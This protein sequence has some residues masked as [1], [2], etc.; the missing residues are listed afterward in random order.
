MARE[1]YASIDEEK[2]V[3]AAKLAEI[4]AE[5]EDLSSTY[6]N[7]YVE[8]VKDDERIRQKEEDKEM[9]SASLLK[10]DEQK[11]HKESEKMELLDSISAMKLGRD[12]AENAILDLKKIVENSEADISAREEELNS[13]K[14]NLEEKRMEIMKIKNDFEV[15]QNGKEMLEA[16]LAE[17]Q[18]YYENT[19]REI[20]EHNSRAR[21][22]KRQDRK[23]T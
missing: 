16:R 11:G 17:L 1:K 18:K 2:Q 14:R 19:A 8:V 3:Q 22:P 21:K 12:A 7:R 10:V 9:V 23:R 4:Q 5:I 13:S 15:E 20:E 6:H